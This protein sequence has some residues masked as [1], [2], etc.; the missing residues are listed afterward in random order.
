M[1]SKVITCSIII[2][3]PI[4]FKFIKI[5]GTI[6]EVC[7]ELEEYPQMQIMVFRKKDSGPS[8]RH[9]AMLV[10][11]RYKLICMRRSSPKVQNHLFIFI[12][13]IIYSYQFSRA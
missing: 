7:E 8:S 5:L 1:K 3:Q 12:Y 11:S 10:V 2:H 6:T 4:H 9:H 13:S